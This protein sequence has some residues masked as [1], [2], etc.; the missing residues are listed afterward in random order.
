MEPVTT[1]ESARRARQDP[2]E[3]APFPVL[4]PGLEP[5]TADQETADAP[6]V[7][8]EERRPENPKAAVVP[9]DVR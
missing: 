1:R 6:D 4:A 3:P 2:L 9:G 7:L 8:G 5:T